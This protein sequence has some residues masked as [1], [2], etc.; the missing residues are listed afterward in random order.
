[1]QVYYKTLLWADFITGVYWEFLTPVFSVEIGLLE[2]RVLARIKKCESRQHKNYMVNEFQYSNSNME[3]F[4]GG[5][6]NPDNLFFED[7]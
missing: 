5:K 3:S 1:M 4:G 2:F 6:N 7:L